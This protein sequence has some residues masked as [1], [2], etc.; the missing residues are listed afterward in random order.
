M[1]RGRASDPNQATA[2]LV[3]D[4]T[5]VA[6]AT[7]LKLA[8][9]RIVVRT[10][11]QGADVAEQL[12]NLAQLEKLF[13][14]KWGGSGDVAELFGEAF[15]E[16]GDVEA[17]MQWY[18]TRRGGPGR[19]G[20]DEGGGAAGE[21]PRPACL[22]DRRQGGEGSRRHEEAREGRRSDGRRRGP[23]RGARAWTPSDRCGKAITRADASDRAVA[24]AADDG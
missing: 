14:S 16:A 8:L 2:P 23:L 6:S 21:R 4:F 11:F 24:R 1:F 9:E 13:G 18:E 7:S 3:E 12:R 5:G 17:G 10:K 22:G 19:K 15:V 20:V